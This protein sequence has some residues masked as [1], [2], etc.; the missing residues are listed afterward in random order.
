MC[1]F[2]DVVLVILDFDYSKEY[3]FKELLLYKFIVII[4]SY[5]I[6]E[7]IFINGNLFFF[8][9]GFGL[10]EVVDE[11][12]IKNNNF[13]IDEFKYKFFILFNLKGFLKKIK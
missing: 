3:V 5:M 12:L 9:W 7:D 4:G 13:I 1:K 8:D 2:D 10:M 6:V 11:F